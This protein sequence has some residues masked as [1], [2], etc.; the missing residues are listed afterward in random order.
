VLRSVESYWQRPLI[1]KIIIYYRFVDSQ[2]KLK[3]QYFGHQ[4]SRTNCGK[5]PDAGKDCGQEEKWKT[6]DG[7]GLGLGLG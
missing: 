7:L 3:L 1:R 4:M 5:D 6:E 2:L